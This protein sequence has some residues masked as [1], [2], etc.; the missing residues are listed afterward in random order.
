MLSP[1]YKH[2]IPLLHFSL[3]KYQEKE[4]SDRNKSDVFLPALGKLWYIS[5]LVET[6]AD[7]IEYLEKHL[8]QGLA[9]P[10]DSKKRLENVVAETIKSL[11]GWA[12]SV[13]DDVDAVREACE[14]LEKSF[15]YFE[16]FREYENDG[17]NLSSPLLVMVIRELGG[18]RSVRIN[19]F[20]KSYGV[21]VVLED[22]QNGKSWKQTSENGTVK[23]CDINPRT[24][25]WVKS[26]YQYFPEQK[27][28][29]L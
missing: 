8:K 1:Q 26:P 6:C 14:Q 19:H 7:D 4:R 18:N 25:L 29:I 2:K 9:L 23:F 22:P 20:P 15:H 10:N 28:K 16:E 21:E 24:E 12:S 17:E 27:I 13:V 5:G 11:S 3:E